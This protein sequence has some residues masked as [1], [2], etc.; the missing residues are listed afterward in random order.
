MARWRLTASHYIHV[1]GCT[2]T[3]EETDRETGE[4]AKFTYDVPM[5]LDIRSPPRRYN[6]DGY[7]FVTD[8][9][10][11]NPRDV[12]FLGPPTPDM[13]PQDDE[14]K[15]IS[16]KQTWQNPMGEGA[17]PS[18]GGANYGEALTQKFENMMTELTNALASGKGPKAMSGKGVDPDAFAELQKQVAELMSQNAKLQNDA[19]DRGAARRGR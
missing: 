4:V 16:A 12:V 17:F 1:P 7:I 9:P 15:E 2:Y 13:E 6:Q 18:N 10:N 3:R 14:A 5:L 19:A 8:K 11:G